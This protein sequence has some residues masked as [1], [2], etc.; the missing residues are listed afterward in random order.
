[1]AAKLTDRTAQSWNDAAA[2]SLGALPATLRRTLTVDNGS[3]FA[4]FADMQTA[5]GLRVYFADP[6]SAWQRG[7]NENT[8]GLLRR[9]LPKGTDFDQVSQQELA[10]VVDWLNHRP[11][12]CLNY[13]TPHEVFHQA[14]RG[15]VGM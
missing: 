13:R 4:R 5:L 15:A 14:I 2:T 1:M 11:R 6:Y 8:N 10:N 7:A 3:E 9:Y 12:R